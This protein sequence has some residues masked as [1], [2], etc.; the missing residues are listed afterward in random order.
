MRAL[1]ITLLVLIL[2]VVGVDI[3]G[4][5]FAQAKVADA[6]AAQ[7]TAANRPAVSIHGLSF[8]AQAVPGRYG[9]V[10]V[11]WTALILGPV[12]DVTATIDF[13]DVRYPLSDAFRGTVDQLVA[14]R[15][16]LTASIP[17]TSV[18]AA[19]NLP[20]VTLR[21]GAGGR[22][23]VRAPVI[24]GGP[25]LDLSADVRAQVVGNSLR[26]T[27]ANLRAPGT[28]PALPGVVTTLLERSLVLDLPL[29]SLP[30]TVQAA[31]VTA[32]GDHLEVAAQASDV[33]ASELR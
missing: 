26:L 10:T 11:G 4:R 29:D 25:A 28:A 23:E 31:T 1:V 15:A 6:I 5:A 32:V 16:D 18:T 30:L 27:A 12:R 2:L 17:L 9:K 21:A 22:L 14:G 19:L 8:L 24:P 13:S 33:R 7:T 20:G 3:G